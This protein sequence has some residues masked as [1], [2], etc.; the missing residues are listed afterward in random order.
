M[1]E[2]KL[3]KE[4]TR[5]AILCTALPLESVRN[6]WEVCGN[7]IR[8]YLQHATAT[9]KEELLKHLDELLGNLEQ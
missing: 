6:S 9:T 7:F 4:A 8:D 2:S 3:E 5:Y 1:L